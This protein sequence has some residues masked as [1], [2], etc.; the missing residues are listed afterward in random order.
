MID[1]KIAL[2]IQMGKRVDQAC[3]LQENPQVKPLLF[4]ISN[5]MINAA[6]CHYTVFYRKKTS[7]CVRRD[8]KARLPPL[9]GEGPQT[10][11][12]FSRAG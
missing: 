11:A 8:K 1:Q 10:F 7:L 12:P 2:F 5:R 3:V 6:Y 9:C 4:S